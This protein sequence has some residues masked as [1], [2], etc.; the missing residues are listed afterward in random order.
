MGGKVTLRLTGLFTARGNAVVNTSRLPGK[1]EVSLSHAGL[2]GVTLSGNT[3]SY[4]SVYASDTTVAVSGQA[5]LY[6]AA[7]AKAIAALG[8]TIHQ[9]TSLRTVWASELGL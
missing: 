7:L 3:T 4:L 5:E 8:G 6:G 1:L 9:D 2:V